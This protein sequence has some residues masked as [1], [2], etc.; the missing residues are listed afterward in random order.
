M[1]PLK[2]AE[3]HSQLTNPNALVW[4]VVL[5]SLLQEPLWPTQSLL[6]PFSKRSLIFLHIGDI[7]VLSRESAEHLYTIKPGTFSSTATIGVCLLLES[8]SILFLRA[9]ATSIPVTK[10]RSKIWLN[11]NDKIWPD[12]I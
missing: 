4:L 9:P 10:I 5:L 12:I 8:V 7:G 11:L 6:M 1:K 3:N 2:A